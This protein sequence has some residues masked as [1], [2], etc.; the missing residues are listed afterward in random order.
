LH[1]CVKLLFPLHGP[2]SVLA[3]T[4]LFF[5]FPV[6]NSFVVLSQPTWWS[7]HHSEHNRTELSRVYVRLWSQPRVQGRREKIPTD[8]PWLWHCGSACSWQLWKINWWALFPRNN[9][10]GHGFEAVR[11]QP[12]PTCGQYACQLFLSPLRVSPDRCHMSA[13]WVGKCPGCS[14]RGAVGCPACFLCTVTLWIQ[15]DDCLRGNLNLRRAL[16]SETQLLAELSLSLPTCSLAS[17]S[18]ALS[19]GKTWSWWSGARGGHKDD[20]RAG[21]PLLWGKAERVG[22][23][24][25]GEEKAAGTPSYS[26]SVLKGRLQESWRGNFYK[27]V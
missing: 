16:S 11:T 14:E 19:T 10:Q 24:Q 1:V 5:F 21:A 6:N 12:F 3:C 8:F 27:G 7:T 9:R 15:P 26:L 13:P 18:G 23:V 17:G 25:P 20:P 2:V 22:A 4:F